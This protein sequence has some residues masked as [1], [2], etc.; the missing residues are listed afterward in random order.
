MDTLKDM[1]EKSIYII[2]E[3]KSRFKNPAILWSIGKDS[4]TLLW[5]CKKAFFGEVPFK[6]IHLDT[7]YKFDEIYAFRERYAKEW[8]LDL[9]VAKNDDADKTKACPSKDRSECCNLRKT[10]NLKK[11]IEGYGFDA[12]IAGIRRD[13]HGIRNKERYFSPR[14]K[15]SRWNILKLKKKTDG[16]SPLESSQDAEFSGWNI[17]ASDFGEETQHVRIHPLLHWSELDIWEYIKRENIPVVDLYYPKNG[18][19]YRSIGCK[20]CCSPMK[21][22]AD[23]IDKI[24]EELKATKTKER[25][26]R[27]QDKEDEHNMQRLRSLGYM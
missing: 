7:G 26:G 8:K 23:S 2:R 21:S 1:E 15:E 27:A 3:A 9:I 18:E 12:I 4:T 20:P 11:M 16:D 17:Y 19:R 6:V 24:I 13:E 14:D 22:T 5:L 10:Q 25:A